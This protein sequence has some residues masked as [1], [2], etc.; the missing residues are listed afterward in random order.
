MSIYAKVDTR[1]SMSFVRWGT[2]SSDPPSAGHLPLNRRLCLLG[3]ASGRRGGLFTAS[4]PLQRNGVSTSPNV[5]LHLSLLPTGNGGLQP[6]TLE[7]S[8]QRAG[9]AEAEFPGF[10]A[11]RQKRCVPRSS[12]SVSGARRWGNDLFR[13][14]FGGPPSPEGEGRRVWGWRRIAAPT[15]ICVL[16]QG[17][18]GVQFGSPIGL[19]PLP[20]C[21][22]EAFGDGANCLPP[23]GK[24]DLAENACIF[25][26][27]RMRSFSDGFAP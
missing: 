24:V 3:K 9:C 25:R 5:V 10:G 8:G 22:G 12:C 6:K 17:I 13:P 4:P 21:G 11:G 19:R 26:Q 27:R 15:A 20:H 7:T 16:Y 2:T 1:P 18:D 23:M 14:A